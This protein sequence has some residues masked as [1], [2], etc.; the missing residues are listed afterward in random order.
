M[1]WASNVEEAIPEECLTIG[2]RRVGEAEREIEINAT[3]ERYGRF[4]KILGRRLP[5]IYRIINGN[6]G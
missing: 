4:I 6:K 3:G 2:I 5:Q 1:E